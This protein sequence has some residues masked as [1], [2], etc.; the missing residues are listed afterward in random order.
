[1]YDPHGKLLVIEVNA[2]PGWKALQAATDVPVAVRLIEF[3]EGLKND[4]GRC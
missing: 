2:V 4:A 3:L 1:M